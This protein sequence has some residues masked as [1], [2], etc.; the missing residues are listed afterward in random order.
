MSSRTDKTEFL[1]ARV[2]PDTLASACDPHATSW[3]RAAS[4]WAPECASFRALQTIGRVLRSS[5][6]TVGQRSVSRPAGPGH[7]QRGKQGHPRA[8]TSPE[9]AAACY[10]ETPVRRL[11]AGRP[12]HVSCLT[13]RPSTGWWEWSC[14]LVGPPNVPKHAPPRRLIG[15]VSA[16]VLALRGPPPARLPRIRKSCMA[17]HSILLLSRSA[18][19]ILRKI[20]GVG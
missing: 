13:L 6:P 3:K 8:S 11:D 15:Q 4:P 2:Q 5:S 19:R 1:G 7:L 17:W 20:S 9:D 14:I 16:K 10:R 12:E 18:S